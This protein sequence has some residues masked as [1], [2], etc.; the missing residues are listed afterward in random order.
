MGKN[1]LSGENSSKINAMF[2]ATGWNLKKLMDKLV[3]DIFGDFL[4]WIR[5]DFLIVRTQII[6]GW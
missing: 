6:F 5:I 4:N 2:A 3:R 1:Y